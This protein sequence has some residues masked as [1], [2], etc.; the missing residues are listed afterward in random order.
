M[1]KFV[2]N[3]RGTDT[4]AEQLLLDFAKHLLVGYESGDKEIVHLVDTYDIHIMPSMNPGLEN[5]RVII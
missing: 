2:A 5:N 1:V 3:S 4:K